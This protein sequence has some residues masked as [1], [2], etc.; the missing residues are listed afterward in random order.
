[1]DMYH[2]GASIYGE[3]EF[4]EYYPT[5]IGDQKA[6]SINPAF[7]KNPRFGASSLRIGISP[8]IYPRDGW[9]GVYFLYPE[10][11]WGRYPGRNLTGAKKISL[12]ARADWPI[13]VELT[14]GGVNRT[15]QK[16]PDLAQFDSFG[17]LKTGPIEITRTWKNY[18]ISLNGQDLS[19]VIGAFA[20]LIKWKR[21]DEDNA[22]YLDNLMIDLPKLEEPRL[23]QSYVP[24]ECDTRNASNIANTYDQ[25]LVL[26]AFLARVQPDDMK[27]ADILACAFVQA[28]SHDR[29]YHDGRLRN[30]YASGEL[31]DPHLGNTRLPGRWDTHANK[32][33][34]DTYA[35]GSDTGNM[36]WAAI[37][38]VQT[39]ALFYRTRKRY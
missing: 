37:A 33:L 27:R 30:A 18:E 39:H 38:L 21:G 26:L 15:N 20:I 9:A 31:I 23:L 14:A 13:E 7:K 35:V 2:K 8:D 4:A 22:I 6:I 17:P 32:F 11:N 12:W 25:A 29:T 34:E 19:S 10:G 16:D 5:I 28:Q 24:A 3:P 36:A 1:M